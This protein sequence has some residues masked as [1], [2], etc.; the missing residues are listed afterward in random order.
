M[1][2]IYTI[3]KYSFKKIDYFWQSYNNWWWFELN[4]LKIRIKTAIIQSELIQINRVINANLSYIDLL[5]I[6][7]YINLLIKTSNASK[8]KDCT[9]RVKCFYNIYDSCYYFKKSHP[10]SPYRRR[11]FWFTFKKGPT[12]GTFISCSLNI[13][14]WT[15]K[16]TEIKPVTTILP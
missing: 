13:Y 16:E 14:P 8:S 5:F 7:S 9:L 12:F 4:S 3:S 15:E 10:S 1:R 6:L 11:I 2:Y